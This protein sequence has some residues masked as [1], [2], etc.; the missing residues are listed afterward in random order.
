MASPFPSVVRPPFAPPPLSPMLHVFS[1]TLW[2]LPTQMDGVEE[3]QPT[4]RDRMGS[5]MRKEASVSGAQN[6][7]PPC[8]ALLTH[9]PVPPTLT[10]S[11]QCNALA[12]QDCDPILRANSKF[13][14]SQEWQV[15]TTFGKPC[16]GS[17]CPR[18][19]PETNTT[20]EIK[21]LP[22]YVPLQWLPH[23][24]QLPALLLFPD[25][26]MQTPGGHIL[27]LGQTKL[28]A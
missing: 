5:R 28:Y 24:L 8:F 14:C 6:V 10:F 3:Q 17:C 18:D 20:F 23:C 27:A 25:I 19:S 16:T 9:Q 26:T 15:A 1:S 13:F 2:E 22:C 21:I 7:C 11:K 12:G 4:A